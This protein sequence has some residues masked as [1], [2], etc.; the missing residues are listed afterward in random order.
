MLYTTYISCW[1]LL[2]SSAG[3]YLHGLEVDTNFLNLSG[4]VDW[5]VAAQIYS[6]HVIS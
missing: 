5:N 4:E 3:R 2:F 6:L 1:R